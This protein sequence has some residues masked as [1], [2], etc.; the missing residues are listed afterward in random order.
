MS[1]ADRINY[2]IGVINEANLAYH[3]RDEPT[4]PDSHYDLLF[5]ELIE[6]EQNNPNLK[7]IDSP[8][9]R[10]GAKPSNGF[11][12]IK[13]SSPMLSLDNIFNK[14]ELDVWINRIRKELG[15]TD[16]EELGVVVEPKYDG[17]AIS[18]RYEVGVL[19]SASTRGDGLVGEDVTANVKTIATIPLKLNTDSPPSVI[20]IR[21]EVFMYKKVFD[22]LNT[23]LIAEGKK[24]LANPRSAAAGS[25]RQLD[26][27][28]TA[29]RSLGFVPYGIGEYI[30][31]DELASCSCIMRLLSDWGFFSSGVSSYIQ[32]GFDEVAV[33]IDRLEESRNTLPFEID[34]AVIKLDNIGDWGKLGT[35]SRAPKWAVAYKFPAQEAITTLKDVVYQ[36]GRTGVITPVAVLNPVSIGGVTVS[37]ATLHN[38]DEIERLGL[39]IGFDVVIKRAG[40]VI[41]IILGVH[42]SGNAGIFKKIVFPTQ[43]P[44]CGSDLNITKD[45]VAIK[46]INTRG[47]KDQLIAK[48]N[49]FVS[50]DAMDIKGLGESIIE[51]LVTN[52]IVT[53][54]SDL[55]SSVNEDKLRGYLI[56]EVGTLVTDKLM[57]SIQG[58]RFPTPDR[59]IYALGIE[60][61][62]K[63]T[64]SAIASHFLSIQAL[65]LKIASMSRLDILEIPKVGPVATNSLVEYFSDSGNFVEV[66]QLVDLVQPKSYELSKPGALSG[67]SIAITGTWPNI[68][69]EDIISVINKLG[70][71]YSSTVTSKTSYLIA[72]K[73]GGSKLDTA[74]K[75]KIPIINI[76]PNTTKDNLSDQLNLLFALTI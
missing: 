44:S 74:T 1:V 38:K 3:Q 25:L 16:T 27:S 48:F 69:R 70:G 40:D 34:G 7:R 24:P 9:A 31:D 17:L 58:S 68:A 61:I 63:A 20:E 26:P 30:N 67:L 66:E 21:G 55:Y 52:K 22:D 60:H 49:H 2:L 6:L 32:G 5:K 10:V 29:S 50:R 64:A 51:K 46:C 12:T 4:I 37:S 28:V 8:T 75:L 53:A 39:Y 57:D 59:F 19:V 36:V 13:H 72:G 11:S 73:H 14:T 41:P 71:K 65:M 15:L 47:C 18:L 42:H 35:T 33:S 23:R 45:V 54:F 76:S 56:E 43:C 62:G